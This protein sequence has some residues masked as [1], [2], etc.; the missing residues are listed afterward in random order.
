MARTSLSAAEILSDFERTGR[1]DCHNAINAG[2]FMD[3]HRAH[4]GKTAAQV[5]DA[6][7]RGYE[8]AG[9]KEDWLNGATRAQPFDG[10]DP[11]AGYRRWRDGWKS[12]ATPL[13]ET[14]INE[15]KRRRRE[16]DEEDEMPR[17]KNPHLL[18]DR[19]VVVRVNR[20][21]NDTHA[22][23]HRGDLDQ[24]IEQA[25]DQAD[26]DGR[27]IYDYGTVTA[28]DARSA[29]RAQPARWIRLNTERRRNPGRVVADHTDEILEGMTRAIWVTSYA[30]W[31]EG[32]SAPKRRDLLP[33]RGEDW[34]DVAPDADRSAGDAARALALRLEEAN[35]CSLHELYQRACKADGQS[36][37]AALADSF[38]HYMAMQ[39]LETGVRWDDD[40]AP[41]PLR[42]VPLQ[43]WLDD[44]QIMWSPRSFANPARR[45]R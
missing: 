20:D 30:D 44:D 24:A 27:A 22:V 40:H 41:F 45:R 4:P 26:A 42:M 10:V 36:P 5:V 37:S 7:W 6:V 43:A 19:W 23:P 29:R 35:G 18:A 2:D 17:T 11:D 15:Y 14:W 34:N 31:V 33:G 9:I 39:A 13:V 28:R 8:E 38:G 32:L 21:P 3:E 1:Q 12:A 16:E 25:I